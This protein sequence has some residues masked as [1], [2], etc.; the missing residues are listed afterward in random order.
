MTTKVCHTCKR[1]LPA[2]PQYFYKFKYASDGFKSSCKECQGGRFIEREIF[3]EG[4]R[5]CH[6]CKELLPETEEYFLRYEDKKSGKYYFKC[7]CIECGKKRSETWRKENPEKYK[8][9][10]TDPEKAGQRK[11]N[12]RRYKANN[13]EKIKERKKD[14]RVRNK[15]KIMAYDK[16]KRYDPETREKVLNWSRNW[17]AKNAD[18]VAEYNKQY[19]KDNPEYYAMAAEKRRQLELQTENSFSLQE[20]EN[21]KAH[22]NNSCAYCGKHLSR[23]TQDHFIPL[24]KG[25]AYARDNIVP[26]CRSCNSSKHNLDFFE[27]YKNFKHYDPEREAR[28]LDYL[29]NMAIPRE[30]EINRPRNA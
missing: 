14:Y 22:F 21:A 15:D 4:F 25:G 8:A 2:T 24:S 9:Y 28:I 16:K 27:W 1:E 19:S 3:P 17:R 11:E 6:D 30:S 23:L 7:H 20:W 26:A 12:D 10:Y 29:K 13:K 5:R 18:R